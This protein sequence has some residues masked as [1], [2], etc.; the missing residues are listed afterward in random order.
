M[1]A[2]LQQQPAPGLWASRPAY[3]ET[4]HA[5]LARVEDERDHLAQRVGEL[6]ADVAE[7]ESI[8]ASALAR[9]HLLLDV[10]E[11]YEEAADGLGTGS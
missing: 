4:T 1:S 11:T 9:R 3:V 8:L 5:E 7:A 10:V 2:A 6:E